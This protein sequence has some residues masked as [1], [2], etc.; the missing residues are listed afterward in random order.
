MEE[1][2]AKVLLKV[3]LVLTSGTANKSITVGYYYATARARNL[4]LLRVKI[5]VII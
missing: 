4:T 1:L 3:G 5:S 2:G